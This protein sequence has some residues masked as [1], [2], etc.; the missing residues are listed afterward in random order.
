MVT[1]VE[2]ETNL[3]SCKLRDQVQLHIGDNGV[4]EKLRLH[5]DWH[6]VNKMVNLWEM[7]GV[8]GIGTSALE[9]N[10]SAILDDGTVILLSHDLLSEEWYVNS[11]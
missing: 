7:S 5:D 6:R 10:F 4:V 2:C 8:A 1:L 11:H 3:P 9:M